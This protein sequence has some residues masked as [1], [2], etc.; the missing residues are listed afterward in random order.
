MSCV[1][2]INLFFKI[3]L[4]KGRTVKTNKEQRRLFTR[5]GPGL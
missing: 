4:C 3:N 5:E 1:K 2:G